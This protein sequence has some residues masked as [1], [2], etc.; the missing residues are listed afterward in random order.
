[1][2][3]LIRIVKAW[4]HVQCE[5]HPTETQSPCGKEFSGEKKPISPKLCGPVPWVF[6]FVC[7]FVFL[8]S[9][10]SISICEL[11]IILVHIWG[12]VTVSDMPFK[13]MILKINHT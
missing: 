1:M 12:L 2:D 13:S 8:I 9:G 4:C 6:L 7:L 5:I 3:K 10:K 11:E